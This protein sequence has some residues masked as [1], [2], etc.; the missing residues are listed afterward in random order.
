MRFWDIL[1]RTGNRQRGGAEDGRWKTEDGGRGSV[2][3]RQKLLLE[4]PVYS[5]DATGSAKLQRSGMASR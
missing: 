2:G 1:N 5:T 3:T 4:R